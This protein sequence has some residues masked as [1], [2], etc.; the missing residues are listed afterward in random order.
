MKFK[1]LL[2]NLLVIFTSIESC[3]TSEDRVGFALNK[4]KLLNNTWGGGDAN[5][6]VVILYENSEGTASK[7][8][9]IENKKAQT[10]KTIYLGH[11]LGAYI[12]ISNDTVD[13]SL[14]FLH[15]NENTELARLVL[16]AIK[17]IAK[18]KTIRDIKK[19]SNWNWLSAI[20]K[21]VI[22]DVG[23]DYT[24][25]EIL[26][27]LKKSQI[28]KVDL[29]LKSWDDKQSLSFSNVKIFYETRLAPSREQ[30]ITHTEAFRKTFDK[31]GGLVPLG[32]MVEDMLG[33]FKQS[34]NNDSNFKYILPFKN[35]C[36][37]AGGT[38]DLGTCTAAYSEMEDICKNLGG[39]RVTSRDN[40]SDFEFE[41]VMNGVVICYKN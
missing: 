13:I 41:A 7:V 6:K 31:V 25:K 5:L 24:E 40:L 12:P 34:M 3:A 22:F 37:A 1:L 21:Q 14:I 23:Y 35:D 26:E 39:R 20:T 18:R 29:K 38:Y 28:E 16:S 9:V 11:T 19:F 4:V 8:E 17:N 15:E 36:I 2:I 30:K 32:T 27:Y 10:Y 33:D